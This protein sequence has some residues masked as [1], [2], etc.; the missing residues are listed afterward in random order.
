MNYDNDFTNSP[1]HRESIKMGVSGHGKELSMEEI[2][3][4]NR[5]MNEFFRKRGIPSGEGFRGI[6]SN[7]VKNAN[8]RRVA[9]ENKA[10]QAKKQKPQSKN[11][12]R[13]NN[14]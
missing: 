12:R 8:K 13:K 10:G 4:F 11:K 1:N 2:A 3:L 7:E 5:K 6:I 14:D 9:A